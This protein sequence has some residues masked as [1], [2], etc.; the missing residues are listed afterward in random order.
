MPATADPPAPATIDQETADYGNRLA[1]VRLGFASSLFT[2]LQVR[3]RASAE[4]SLRVALT[5]SAW[6]ERRGVGGVSRDRAEVAALLHDV[7]LIGIPD[8]ILLGGGSLADEDQVLTGRR[9]GLGAQIIAGCCDDA[10][11]LH[12]IRC[13]G[14]PFDGRRHDD[15][16]DGERLP[17]AARMIAIVEAFDSMT[18]QQVYRSAL[19]RERSVAELHRS[20]GS[21]FDPDLVRD[22]HAMLDRSPEQTQR[23]TVRRWL[24]ELAPQGNSFWGSPAA[25]A[26]RFAQTGSNPA[27]IRHPLIAHHEILARR[28][29]DGVVF[30][31]GDLTIRLWNDEMQRLCGIDE[32]A[33]VG[34]SWDS[35]FIGLTPQTLG[36]DQ[37]ID[38]CP[39]EESMRR[40]IPVTRSMMRQRRG[41]VGSAIQSPPGHSPLPADL[42]VQCFPAA[43]GG[44][45]VIVRDLSDRVELQDQ[46]ES[47]H[48][49]ATRDGLTGA[50][51]RAE[52]D[53]QVIRLVEQ[54][55]STGRT[56]GAIIC[57]IDHFKKVN[58]LHGHA[59]GDEALIQFAAILQ[60]H[61]R[62]GDIVA[63]YG[64]E[65]FVVLSPGS[66][67]A[68][69]AARAEQIRAAIEATPLSGLG[70]ASVTCSFGVT[71][72]QTGDEPTTVICRADR[73]LLQAKS[74]GRNCVVQ[75]GSGGILHPPAATKPKSP[76]SPSTK[77]WA[78]W[79]TRGAKSRPQSLYLLTTPVPVDLVVEKL[80]GFVADHEA[81]VLSVTDDEVSLQLNIRC[82]EGRRA[83]DSLT[84][85][86]VDLLLQQQ[87][88]DDADGR[89]R[90]TVNQ[91]TIDVEVTAAGRRTRRTE[92]LQSAIDRIIASLRSYL[93]AD[94][95]EPRDENG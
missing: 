68:T 65:E 66:D 40:R 56:F 60:N 76:R 3:H 22:F 50:I 1:T 7:G 94:L 71:E 37:P 87:P 39:V 41:D 58:D 81:Q 13:I 89:G 32:T 85:L 30:I 25:A 49:K 63:R 12:I 70:G 64:G 78:R 83:S 15:Q 6:C 57:D 46:L 23:G 52:M 26:D 36:E 55:M 16:I 2:A 90:R 5:I 18:T 27:A 53:L 48:E 59:A 20:A 11:L 43:A 77:S 10:E 35:H 86:Q 14:L 67:N 61:S 92:E 74:G 33:I 93:M 75:L 4:H 62:D 82:G 9:F 21:R 8:R 29:R 38:H 47:L 95:V 73:A 24:H 45:V 88:A 84:R 31:D 42:L 51:N 34:Q 44:I 91:T 80:K 69:T 17:I 19:S 54:A 79:L 28:T 72:Y